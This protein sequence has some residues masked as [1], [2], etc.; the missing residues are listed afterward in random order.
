MIHFSV[1][2][3][4]I[5]EWL[6]PLKLINNCSSSIIFD[7]FGPFEIFQSLIGVRSRTNIHISMLHSFTQNHCRLIHWTTF[8][9]DWLLLVTL[10]GVWP[11]NV[12]M[13]SVQCSWRCVHLHFSDRNMWCY[14]QIL[15]QISH[16][17]AWK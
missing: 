5:R 12:T 2:R 13:R 1:T 7:L 3:I 6:Y 15:T 16:W 4:S 14:V 8:T 9:L 17:N 11:L 10:T